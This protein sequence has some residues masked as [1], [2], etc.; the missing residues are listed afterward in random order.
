MYFQFE[1][2]PLMNSNYL[3]RFSRFYTFYSN[4]G[5]NTIHKISEAFSVK[6]CFGFQENK[7]KK[8]Q[9]QLFTDILQN[10][11]FFKDSLAQALSCEFC[12]ILKN[13]LFTEHLLKQSSEKNKN[14]SNQS[15]IKSL[16]NI[17]KGIIFQR[18]LSINR[19]TQKQPFMM[20]YQLMS[21][22]QNNFKW[23]LLFNLAVQSNQSV[24]CSK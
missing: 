12:E 13:I 5:H 7:I 10:R 15:L 16:K 2:L 21:F 9:K 18:R 22:S 17:F 8:L 20:I 23:L 14:K 6:L 1:T 4:V 24:A 3:I 19:F 11:Y